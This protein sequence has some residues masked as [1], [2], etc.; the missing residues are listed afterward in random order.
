MLNDISNQRVALYTK[1]GT[2]PFCMLAYGLVKDSRSFIPHEVHATECGARAIFKQDDTIICTIEDTFSVDN[3]D[4]I[5]IDRKVVLTKPGAYRIV[6]T[7]LPLFS[8][9]P[10]L[11]V[12]AV[13]YKDN[14]AGKGAFPRKTSKEPEWSFIESRTPLPG[15]TILHS[16][17]KGFALCSDA[18]R[19]PRLPIS[20]S[21]STSATGPKI[22][23]W[24][25]GVEWP[26]RYSGKTTLGPPIEQSAQQT[27]IVTNDSIPFHITN[28]LYMMSSALGNNGPFGFFR[29][30]VESYRNAQSATKPPVNAL[31]WK[32]Y[33]DLKFLHLLSLIEPVIPGKTACLSMGR[34][35]GGFQHV[36]EYTAGSFLVKSLEAAV[37]LARTDMDKLSS[38]DREEIARLA[39]RLGA[40]ECSLS[41]IAIMIGR[42]FLQGERAPG[43]HQDCYDRNRKIWGGYLGISEHDDFRYLVNARC[44]GEV[45]TGYVALY[46]ILKSHGHDIIEF[47]E[48]PKRVARFYVKHQFKGRHDG[49]F[50]RWWSPEGKP[51]NSLGTNG[52]YIVSFLCAIEPYMSES[53]GISE[54]LGRAASYYGNLVENGEYFGDT[55]DAD[56]CDKEAGVVLMSMFC[57]LYERDNREQWIEYAR[58]AGEFVASWIWQ[59]DIAFPPESP[60]AKKQFSTLGMTSVSIAHHHLDFF[61][62]LIAYGFL[63]LWDHTADQFFY[64]QGKLLLNACRQLIAN[65][66]DTLGRDE[67]D[68]GWQPEQLNHTDWD[69]FDRESH[70]NGHYDIDIAW[71]TVLGL[72]AFQKINKQYPKILY[73]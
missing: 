28:R 18:A 13:L 40:P 32:K 55:L 9:E 11:F 70:M 2:D 23:L 7:C 43:V 37:I 29:R 61:G 52:A 59:Y 50:G 44:N 47:L 21:C 4:F 54:A 3:S 46:E 73:N 25:P 19:L 8:E 65:S 30:F 39:V 64:G 20:A 17:E 51:V 63:R 34:N 58:K 49:S 5:T 27:Y 24:E 71:V 31:P 45:M 69:Y 1:T 60:L 67:V 38:E 33:H 62:M 16:Q 53:D 42:F 12:P 56:S 66:Q 36:Y 10:E 14:R 26:R 35:N 57:D 72:G 41:E 22:E 6:H 48:L 15:I 68:I